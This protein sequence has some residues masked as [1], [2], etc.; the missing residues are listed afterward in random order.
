MSDESEHLPIRRHPARFFDVLEPGERASGEAGEVACRLCGHRCRLSEGQS[1]ICGV[2]TVVGGSLTTT[3][4][5]GFVALNVDPI[6]KKP[7]FHFHPGSDC[8]SLATPGCNF[9]CRF[10]QNW[11]ISQV[12]GELRRLTPLSPREAVATAAQHG[13]RAIAF[14][15]SEPTIF[16]EYALEIAASA[17]GAGID[18]VLVSNGF[19]TPEVLDHIGPLLGG[20]NIDLKAFR[21]DTYRSLIGGRLA[22]VLETLRG[23]IR[24]GVWLEV[25]TLVIPG[26]NDSWRELSSIARFIAEDLGPH[27]PWHVSRFHSAHEMTGIGPTP[28]ESLE[29]ACAAGDEAGLRYVYAGNVPAHA[30]EHTHCHACDALLIERRGFVLRRVALRDGR[31]PRCDTPAAGVWPLSSAH[32]RGG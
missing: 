3:A 5:G 14:T 30:R 15:Y 11:T 19:L 16:I 7:L 13:C 4:Y 2:R 20:A 24:H 12:R 6:E 28:L 26:V 25:T 23:L 18:C 8:L 10:C 27:V 22:P 17:R 1:G 29:R 31:C 9:R 32:G 21:D